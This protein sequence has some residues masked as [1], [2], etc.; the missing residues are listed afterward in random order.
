MWS[1]LTDWELTDCRENRTFK[2]IQS[3]YFGNFGPVFHL[4]PLFGDQLKGVRSVIDLADLISLT[5]LYRA[6]ANRDL[7]TRFLAFLASFGELYRRI[8]TQRKH[9]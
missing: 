9:V 8:L 4:Q 2:H 6:N 7:L 1:D 5:S 3:S